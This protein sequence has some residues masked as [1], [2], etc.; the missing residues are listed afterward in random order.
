[1]AVVAGSVGIHAKFIRKLDKNR[2]R[3][4][5]KERCG[6]NSRDFAINMLNLNATLTPQLVGLFNTSISINSTA[7]EDV[8]SESGAAVLIG[9]K[10]ETALL[11]FAKDLGWAN[12]KATRD[13]A[14][15]IQMIPF[16][17]ERKAMGCVV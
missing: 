11:N 8:H 1:M 3:A 15:V 16:S 2:T 12:Y 5:D 7:F 10:T 13:A 14:N 6:T 17:S 4:G 9:S